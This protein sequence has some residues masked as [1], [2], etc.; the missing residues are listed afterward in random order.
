MEYILI[1]FANKGG[2]PP[3]CCSEWGGGPDPP[4][5]NSG[6][7]GVGVGGWALIRVFLEKNVV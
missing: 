7:G 1:F 2:I 3:P 5:G 6:Y 4:A